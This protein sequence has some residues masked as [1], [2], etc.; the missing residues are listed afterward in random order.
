M[1]LTELGAT[2]PER[3]RRQQGQ[4]RRRRHVPDADERDWTVRGKEE[5]VVI[6]T[7]PSHRKASVDRTLL[8]PEVLARLAQERRA[9]HQPGRAD[10]SA[11]YQALRVGGLQRCEILMLAAS[12]VELVTGEVQRDHEARSQP[13]AAESSTTKT[14]A[15]LTAASTSPAVKDGDR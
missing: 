3:Q 1:A 10:A 11:L 13:P 14:S 6:A 7:L 9:L 4:Y 15:N 5:V 8:A 2:S 12:L